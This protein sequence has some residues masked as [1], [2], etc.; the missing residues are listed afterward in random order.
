[1]TSLRAATAAL[2]AV[3]L[4][5]VSPPA[6]SAEAGA[7]CA[8]FPNQAAAQRAANTRDADG[9]GIYC[10]SLPCPCLRPGQPQPPTPPTPGPTP[11]VPVDPTQEQQVEPPDTTASPTDRIYFTGSY[12]RRYRPRTVYFG[13]SQRIIRIRWRRWNGPVAVGRGTYPV[14]DCIPY[15]ARGT[16]TNFPVTVR[17]SRRRT[18]G[19]FTE[20]LT[21]TRTYIGRG[22]SG[23]PRR[24]RINFRCP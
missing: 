16:V 11:P 17:L 4:V 7:T 21:L 13:A 22:P 1:M 23:S 20:Y 19:S 3:A 5:L 18:C 15:C 2:A 9:D 24:Q 6:A 12:R 10:E 14:N 8:D